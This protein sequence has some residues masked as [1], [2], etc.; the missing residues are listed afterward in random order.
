M[1]GIYDCDIITGWVAI[2]LASNY[3]LNNYLANN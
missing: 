3:N 2:N 1:I